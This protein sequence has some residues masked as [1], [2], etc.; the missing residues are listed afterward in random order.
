MRD[1]TYIISD[2]HLGSGDDSL[3]RERDLVCFLDSI[4]ADM[5]TLVLLGDIFD[6]WFTYRYVVP[7]GHA[8]FIGKLAQLSD[9]GVEIHYFIGN[10]DM[11]VFDYFHEET[12][13]IMHD[14]PVILTLGGHRLLLG[15]GDG[16]ENNDPHYAFLKR[17]FRSRFNQ[18]LFAF[19]HPSIGFG[20]AT[21]WSGNSR[22]KHP[23]TGQ[24]YRGDDSEGIYQY[25]KR[26]LAQSP[27]E[28]AVFG[29]RHGQVQRPI[30]IAQPARDAMYC[31][32]GNWIERRDYAVIDVNG[33]TLTQ[34]ET[35]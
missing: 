16:L 24:R 5:H 11:W 17:M 13:A 14:A 33:L 26:M 8:R 12:G 34:Y 7:R 29:H 4:A 1:K 2:V 9:M 3:R 6:F 10:H 25:A 22:K 19:L 35:H 21:R 30:H 23:A 15:H 27:F 28:Y 32:V 31:N 18:R 20:I